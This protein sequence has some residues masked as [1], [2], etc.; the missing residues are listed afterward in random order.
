MTAT[1]NQR[2]K[3]YAALQR[4]YPTRNIDGVAAKLLR[5]GATSL[6]Y[7][8][9]DC[10]DEYWCNHDPTRERKEASLERRI[11]EACEE[12]PGL[13]PDLSGQNGKN[14]SVDWPPVS[15]RQTSLNR[16]RSGPWA[17][18]GWKKC[19]PPST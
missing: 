3:F 11:K 1:P 13:S 18:L 14:E 2:A 8:E 9:R 7:A 12:L 17:G 5:L 16:L 6:L 15:N 10:S 19:D 4:E